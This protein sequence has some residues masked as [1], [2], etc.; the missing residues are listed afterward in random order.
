MVDVHVC[1]I[2]LFT[3]M[4][5]VRGADVETQ[6][7]YVQDVPRHTE[8]RLGRERQAIML[9]CGHPYQMWNLSTC[10][11]LG[12]LILTTTRS[13]EIQEVEGVAGAN[14]LGQFHIDF[15]RI[16]RADRAVSRR[17]SKG[18]AWQHEFNSARQLQDM[19]SNKKW[20]TACLQQVEEWP[21]WNP[22][23]K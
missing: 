6:A 22:W 23:T 5:E 3:E 20:T 21:W 18:Q 7:C 8:V 14:S 15:G 17:C 13:T 16:T 12:S 19:V 10:E 11:Y 4:V 1:Y 9:L 2:K